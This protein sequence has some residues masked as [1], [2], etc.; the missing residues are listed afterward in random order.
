MYQGSAYLFNYKKSQK[1]NS[2][3]PWF[4]V[5]RFYHES[6]DKLKKRVSNFE[7]FQIRAPYEAFLSW[8]HRVIK[9]KDSVS[10]RNSL[11]YNWIHSFIPG[12]FVKSFYS[13]D[14]Q[15]R[16]RFRVIPLAQILASMR[17]VRHWDELENRIKC[18]SFE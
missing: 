4:I 1:L 8:Q 14:Q 13:R 9:T 10:Y 18:V 6:K 17:V 3:I 11:F 2:I 7:N 12:F 5:K 16:R 15:N